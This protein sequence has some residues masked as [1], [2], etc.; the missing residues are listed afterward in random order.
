[1]Q[2]FTDLQNHFSKMS[3]KFKEHYILVNK[4]TDDFVE[5]DARG[6]VD[7][8]NFSELSWSSCRGENSDISQEFIR[9]SSRNSRKT[10]EE[11]PFDIITTEDE[12]KF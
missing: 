8:F 4:N 6:Q 1:M 7:N 9:V 10:S 5:I 11:I 3:K 12:K 2:D